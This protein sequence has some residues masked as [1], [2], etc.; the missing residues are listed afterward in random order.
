MVA[1]FPEGISHDEVTLQPLKTGA[2]RIAL[3]AADDAGAE[4]LVTVAVGLVYDAKARF[5]SRAL[6][7]VGRAGEGGA[8]GRGVRTRRAGHGAA[9]SPRTWPCSSSASIPRSPRGRRPRSSPGSPSW[10]CAVPDADRSRRCR[11]GRPGACRGAC[12]AAAPGRSPESLRQLLVGF[13]TYERDL[14]LLGVSDAQ[15]VAGSARRRLGLRSWGPRCKVLVALPFAAIGALVHVIPFQIMK[16]VGN[17]RPTRA[18]RPPSSCWVASCCSPRPTPWSG[19][20]SARA[21]GTWAGLG[22]ALAAPL[23]GFLTVRVLERVRRFGGVVEGIGLGAAA[24]TSCAQCWRHRGDRGGDPGP[25]AAVRPEAVR[26]GPRSGPGGRGV[27][28]PRGN[29]GAC[30]SSS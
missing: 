24:G 8:M 22:A 9:P 26:Y 21:Y 18:S 19:C 25:A 1:V 10:S 15:L 17:G 14:E 12:L 4:D 29:G 27:A 6:V 16:Q 7:R 28:A 30:R 5:R 23:C 13:A 11:A 3:E 2:A 20:S